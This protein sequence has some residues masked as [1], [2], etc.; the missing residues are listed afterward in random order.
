[1]TTPSKTAQD[2]LTGLARHSAGVGLENAP[3]AKCGDLEGIRGTW[4][5]RTAMDGRPQMELT[6]RADFGDG[7]YATISTI[8]E[9]LP[10]TVEMLRAARETLQIES[11]KVPAPSLTPMANPVPAV[12][13]EKPKWTGLLALVLTAVGFSVV[14]QVAISVIAA[15][16]GGR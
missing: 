12:E 15:V 11:S 14:V 7:R 1:M 2:D 9:I 5:I 10:M 4:R 6:Q 16:G 3:A 13:P 8:S